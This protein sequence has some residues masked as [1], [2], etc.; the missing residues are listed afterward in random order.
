MSD[1][2]HYTTWEEL[3]EEY[4]FA[5][6]LRAAT[7]WSYAKVVKGF[8][9]FTGADITPSMV[10]HHEVLRWRRHVLR[11]KQQSAQTWNNKIAHLRALYNYAME[12][13]LLPV[14]KTLLTIALY[15][16]TERKSG[17]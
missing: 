8:L 17:L 16:G 6:N 1:K 2:N 7:E 11:E 5:R 3:L 15:S 14:A 13:G 12:S 9:K 10:T 4:F